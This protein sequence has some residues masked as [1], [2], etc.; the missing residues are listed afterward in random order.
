M[1]T[2]YPWLT[3]S[4]VHVLLIQGKP[5]MG[6]EVFHYQSPRSS[7]H[8]WQESLSKQAFRALWRS[9]LPGESANSKGTARSKSQASPPPRALHQGTD[10]SPPVEQE[11]STC[12]GSSPWRLRAALH[13]PPPGRGYGMQTKSRRRSR[14]NRFRSPRMYCR[15]HSREP[16]SKFSDRA[17]GLG[18]RADR[19]R[20][21]V[22]HSKQS[23]WVTVGTAPVAQRT[24]TEIEGDPSH[25]DGSG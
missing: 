14:V 3:L 2:N 5:A 7:P 10:L 22:W 21:M 20:R 25:H 11:G 9:D 8:G 13:A 17:S 12:L 18:S 6:A 1:F 19:D 16:C 24:P 4:T 15:R 23:G